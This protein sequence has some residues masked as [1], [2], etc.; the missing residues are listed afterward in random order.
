VLELKE[1]FA[2]SSL[3]SARDFE[4]DAQFVKQHYDTGI[5]LFQLFL[6]ETMTY[7]NAVYTHT[8]ANI[9]GNNDQYQNCRDFDSNSR[10]F[11]LL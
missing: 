4:K 1:M 6:D 8:P 10:L 11:I 3:R 5:E 2:L 9:L 7:T